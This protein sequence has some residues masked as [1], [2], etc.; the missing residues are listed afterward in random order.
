MSLYPL[1]FDP[2]FKERIWGGWRMEEL[3]NKRLPPHVAIGESWEVADRDDSASKVNNGPLAGKTLSWIMKNHGAELMGEAQAPDGRFPLLV[4]IL[5]ARDKLS[6]QVH[7][8]ANIAESLGGQPKTEMWYIAEA[9]PEAELYAGLKKGVGKAEFEAKLR[10]GTVQE[11]FHRIPVKTGDAMFLPSGRVHAIGQGLV[12]FEIQQNSDTTYRVYDWDRTDPN[13][14]SR[15]LHVEQSLKSIDFGDFEPALVSAKRAWKGDG[16]ELRSLV[17]DPLFRVEL[18]TA[19][20][21]SSLKLP[22]KKPQVVACVS[23]E[24]TILGKNSE[25]TLEAGAFCLVPASTN[26]LVISSN[27]AS[28]FLLANPA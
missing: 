24:I 14:K 4:K 17:N 7:P 25:V 6:L 12:I 10:E 19:E 22:I 5:D 8:P 1:T 2:I 13:G 11:C 20:E 26:T 9:D 21:G 23:G 3:F 16:V 27:A 18:L 15:E 28:R